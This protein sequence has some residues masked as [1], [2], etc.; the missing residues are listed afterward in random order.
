MYNAARWIAD[1]LPPDARVAAQNSGIFQYY[2]ERVVLNFDG[3][4]NHEII[5]VLEQREL[6]TYL[7]ERGISYIVDLPGVADYIEFYS[8]R[9]SEAPRHAEMS[10]LD[11]LATYGRLIAARLGLGPP[12]QLDERE[13]ERIIR[14]FESFAT[15]IE[16]FPL[17]NN[18]DSAV[19]VYRLH[20][21][22]G[23]QP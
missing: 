19:L 10:A 5:P 21:E 18:P 17:P 7:R 11:K 8:S 3:K 20:D 16:R 6:D 22:F 1:N 15:V 2:S 23:S 12:V 13:P 9:M 4:L 14:P